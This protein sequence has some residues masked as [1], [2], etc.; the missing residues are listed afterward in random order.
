MLLNGLSLRSMPVAEFATIAKLE[1]IR[2]ASTTK[3]NEAF[4][5]LAPIRGDVALQLWELWKEID[6]LC[7]RAEP[8]KL[9]LSDGAEVY[10]WLQSYRRDELYIYIVDCLNRT[11]K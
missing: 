3:L 6:T 5:D 10:Q 1:N 4:R 8:L 7:R 11:Q 2:F 9:D